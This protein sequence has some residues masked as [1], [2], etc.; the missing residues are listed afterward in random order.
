MTL[1]ALHTF[2]S[3]MQPVLYLT[4][5]KIFH[6]TTVNMYMIMQFARVNTGG[7]KSMFTEEILQKI[8]LCEQ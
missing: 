6:Q 3:S 5:W 8:G 2:P 7:G 4:Q 1:S